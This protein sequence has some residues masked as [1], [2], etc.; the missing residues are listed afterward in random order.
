VHH[1][2]S[3]VLYHVILVRV[4]RRQVFSEELAEVVQNTVTECSHLHS[5]VLRFRSLG[6]T[7]IISSLGSI[8]HFLE[9]DIDEE[10]DLVQREQLR[11]QLVDKVVSQLTLTLI[12]QVVVVVLFVAP[13]EERAL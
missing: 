8:I 2:A 5:D 11:H 9:N 1:D 4:A 3:Q 6:A 10:H 7:P 13:M 12:F